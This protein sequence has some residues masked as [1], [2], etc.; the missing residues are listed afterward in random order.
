M[1]ITKKKLLLPISI[2]ATALVT[3]GVVYAF[4]S[5]SFLTKAQ[6]YVSSQCNS[7]LISSKNTV[8]NNQKA[9]VCYNYYK[10][11]EQ[12]N[13][14]NNLQ[15]TRV[16]YLVDGN[17]NILGAFMNSDT[18]FIDF[19]DKSINR[20][21]SINTTNGALNNS[22]A[23]NLFFTTNDCSGIAYAGAVGDTSHLWRGWGDT[24]YFIVATSTN[25]IPVSIII[26]SYIFDGTC[27]NGQNGNPNNVYLGTST[28]PTFLPLTQVTPDISFPIALP[29]SIK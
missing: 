16:P 8:A 3:G 18:Y 11:I 5:S 10:N 15:N 27:Y 23:T 20:I 1:K 17:N 7:A 19:Y 26:N 13:A 12:D 24:R 2:V 6:N 28:S 14:I 4:S 29:I 21:V 22:Y 9:T 25:N